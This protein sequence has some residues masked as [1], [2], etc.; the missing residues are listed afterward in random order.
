MGSIERAYLEI[1]DF[2][3]CL[4]V[5][6]EHHVERDLQLLLRVAQM[7]L[8][9]RAMLVDAYAT[10]LSRLRDRMR[11]SPV[12][13]LTGP[14]TICGHRTPRRETRRWSARC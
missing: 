11:E 4:P 3:M 8:R 5:V 13:T 9:N 12:G 2:T 10:V 1:A 14:L 7:G 6:R